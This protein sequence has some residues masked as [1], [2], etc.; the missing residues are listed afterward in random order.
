MVISHEGFVSREVSGRDPMGKYE[1]LVDS[2]ND[3][4]HELNGRHRAAGPHRLPRPPSRPPSHATSSFP[5]FSSNEGTRRSTNLEDRGSRKINRAGPQGLMPRPV[6]A[7]SRVKKKVAN[8][9]GPYQSASLSRLERP[10]YTTVHT[11]VVHRS[12]GTPSPLG[13]REKKHECRT[14]FFASGGLI[15]LQQRY[16]IVTDHCH[17]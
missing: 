4:V 1:G 12:S 17:C 5:S 16:V 14:S 8:Y 2:E 7:E 3:T 13:G 11:T 15:S 9:L 6:V 10:D